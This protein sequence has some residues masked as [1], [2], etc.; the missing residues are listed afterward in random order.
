M[1]SAGALLTDHDRVSL[2]ADHELLFIERQL[3]LGYPKADLD[4]GTACSF[5]VEKEFFSS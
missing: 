5:T 3:N 2:T 1:L 4:A